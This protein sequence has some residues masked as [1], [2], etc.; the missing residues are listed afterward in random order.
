[1]PWP[2][3]RCSC[4][5]ETRESDDEQDGDASTENGRMFNFTSILCS[6]LYLCHVL[7]H[8]PFQTSAF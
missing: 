3:S 7:F 2:S 6:V 5:R 8:I 1:M 4:I